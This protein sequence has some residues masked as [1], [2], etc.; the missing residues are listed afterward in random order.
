M[1]LYT[2]AETLRANTPYA[3]MVMTGTA[4]IGQGFGWS[5]G[6]MLGALGYLAYAVAGTLWFMI[7]ICP[8]CVYFGTTGCPCGYGIPAAKMARKGD[9]VCFS[10][11]FKRHVPVIFPLWLAPAGAGGVALWRS[12]SWPLGVLAVLFALDAFIILPLASRRHSC[13]D[14]PQKGECPWMG[15]KKGR[16]LAAG[17]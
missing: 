11:K 6:A 5:A 12:F 16:A 14:C 15:S 1:R 13:A 10:E 9:R 8:Y 7:F 3:I 17:R 2:T 4:I